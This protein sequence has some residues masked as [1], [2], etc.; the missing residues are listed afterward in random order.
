MFLV[1]ARRKEKKVD[2]HEP[3]RL[4]MIDIERLSPSIRKGDS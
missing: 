2:F 3:Q 1:A 4:H